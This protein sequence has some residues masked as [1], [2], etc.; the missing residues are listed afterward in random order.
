MKSIEQIKYD[1]VPMVEC[2]ACNGT[3]RR[4]LTQVER[5]TLASIDGSWTLTSQ[6][7]YNLGGRVTWTATLN[8]LNAL[9]ALGLVQRRDGTGRAIE[10]RVA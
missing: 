7:R 2:K 10:W 4:K 3:G 1:N 6:I 9:V 5:D 8:R